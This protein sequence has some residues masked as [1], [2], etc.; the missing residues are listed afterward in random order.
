M[1]AIRR[2]TL[3]GVITWT[4]GHIL[5]FIVLDTIPVVL[6]YFFEF[7]WLLMPWQLI[8]MIGI[9]VAFYLGFKNNSSYERL[10][11]ARKIWGGIVNSS[12]SFTVMIRDLISNEDAVEFHND[13]SLASIHRI[14]INRHIAWLYALTF[15]LRKLQKWEHNSSSDQR[16]RKKA[17]MDITEENFIVLNRYLSHQD[18]E[19]V[20]SKMNYASH[21]LSLQ[22]RHLKEIKMMGLIDNFRHIALA[23][24]IEKCYTLQG[25]CERIKYF[26]FPRQYTSGSYFFVCLFLFFLPFSMLSVF[27]TDFSNMNLIW[28]SIPVSV[29]ASWVFW[30][31]EWIGDYSENPFEG[32][33]NDI[34][35]T[36]ITRKIEID[37]CQML[38][39]DNLPPLLSWN[40]KFDTSY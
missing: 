12:R 6:Y 28:L 8:P 24:M 37:I 4:K 34:P 13:V 22:S 30:L 38:D 29:L 3:L 14:F 5:A 2:Y 32:L 10:W 39:E 36:D 31:M 15:Q 27:V 20:M 11:E 19:Y 33:P 9:A 21:I 26:P 1:Q 7:E 23:G 35:I 17:G 25:Q 18:Y 16:L 40:D